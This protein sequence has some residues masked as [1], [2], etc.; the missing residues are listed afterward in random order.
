MSD[1]TLVGMF[2][3]K[4]GLSLVRN[5]TSQTIPGLFL[6]CKLQT[7]NLLHHCPFIMMVCRKELD[8]WCPRALTLWVMFFSACGHNLTFPTT[9]PLQSKVQLCSRCMLLAF[10]MKT[11]LIFWPWMWI[12]FS[13]CELGILMVWSRE[14]HFYAR[15]QTRFLLLSQSNKCHQVVSAPALS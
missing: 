9:E 3:F 13:V 12:F 2:S 8:Y 4:I 11:V 5:C 15:H 1:F 10:Y 7:C 6:V 14:R